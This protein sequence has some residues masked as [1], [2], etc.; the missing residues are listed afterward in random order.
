MKKI[1]IITTLFFVTAFVAHA[2]TKTENITV[3]LIVNSDQKNGFKLLESFPKM[4]SVLNGEAHADSVHKIDST[5]SV[6]V[7]VAGLKTEISKELYNKILDL[8]A[9]KNQIREIQCAE[10]AFMI[11]LFK[12]ST[13]S[14]LIPPISYGQSYGPHI[15]N[16]SIGR[17]QCQPPVW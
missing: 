3:S 4:F 16:P 6:V 10:K 14:A 1:V 13:A 2:Q 9:L 8:Y 12:I 17:S 15:P 11:E 7:F 5:V